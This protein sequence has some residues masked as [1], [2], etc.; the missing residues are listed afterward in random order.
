MLI[1]SSQL[2]L[3]MVY[4]AVLCCSFIHCLFSVMILFC[5]SRE[6]VKPWD[7]PSPIP[8]WV[9][10]FGLLKVD[11]PTRVGRG[12]G[13][14]SHVLVCAPSNSALDEIVIRLLSTGLLD[15]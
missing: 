2:I 10:T 4:F 9:D 1:P 13:R 11:S 3:N 15:E 12:V 5:I 14:K 7:P 8:S 6:A